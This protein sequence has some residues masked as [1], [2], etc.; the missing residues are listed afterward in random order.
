[1]RIEDMNEGVQILLARMEAHPEEFMANGKWHF[2]SD[3]F[4]STSHAEDRLRF[5]EK[6]EIKALQDGLK[7]M[8]R[9]KFTATILSKLTDGVQGELF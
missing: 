5:L 1:M 3:A 2:I 9:D 6:E 7:K 4:T 8:Y